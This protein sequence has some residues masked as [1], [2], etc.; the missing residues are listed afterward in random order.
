[1]VSLIYSKGI[2][3]AK[4]DE[5]QSYCDLLMSHIDRMETLKGQM[6]SFWDDENARLAAQLLELQL[7][8]TRDTMNGI[9]ETIIF[10]KN[11]INQL[12][13]AGDAAKELLG[14]ALEILGL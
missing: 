13:T 9:Q 10:Y 2:Y 1:M 8:H 14:Q 3:E 11:S 5:L 4:I 12:G 6:Y 7:K